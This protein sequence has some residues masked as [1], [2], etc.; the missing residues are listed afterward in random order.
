MACVGNCNGDG[1]VTVDELIT[2]V[3]I[4][5][6]TANV[7]ACTAGDANSDGEVTV[8]EIIAGVINALTGCGS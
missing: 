1:E 2:M 4:A 8:N 5:L 6:G 7:T 3:N